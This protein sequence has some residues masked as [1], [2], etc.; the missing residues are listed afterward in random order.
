MGIEEQ[1]EKVRAIVGGEIV[2]AHSGVPYLRL[3]GDI[4]VL[5]LRKTRRFR[6]YRGRRTHDHVDFAEPEGARGA[7]GE[8]T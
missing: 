1:L 3:D 7:I 5:W 2:E 8:L 4:R 6:A